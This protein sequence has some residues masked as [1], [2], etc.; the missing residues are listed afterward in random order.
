VEDLKYFVI[1]FVMSNKSICCD[2]SP[3]DNWNSRLDV[4][5]LKGVGEGVDHRVPAL[6]GLGLGGIATLRPGDEG[7]ALLAI[8]GAIRLIDTIDVVH[9]KVKQCLR[10]TSETSIAVVLGEILVRHHSPESG[11]FV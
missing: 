5:D 11:D 9:L 2:N 10:G 1:I 3:A 6:L 8:L 7:F 4:G